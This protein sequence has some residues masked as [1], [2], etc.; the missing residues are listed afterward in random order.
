LTGGGSGGHITPLLSLARELKAQSPGC[1]I[2]YIGHKGDSFD[3]F[4]DSG[5]D[6]DFMA[7]VKAGKLRRYHGRGMAASVFNPKTLALNIRDFFRLP[8]SVLAAWHLLRKFKPDVVFSKGGFVAVPVGVAAKLL[9]IPIITHDSDAMPGLA[10]RIVGR[11]AKIHATGM[12]PENYSYPKHSIEYVGIPI[13]ERIKKVTPKIQAESKQRLKLPPDSSVLLVSGGGN[14][15]KRLNDLTLSIAPELLQTN[16]SLHIIHITGRLHESDVK[17]AYQSFPKPVRGRVTT[18]GYSRDFYSYSAAADLVISRGG[19][20][21]LAELSAAAKACIVI[22]APFLTGGH[23]LKN[24]E[25]LTRR[26]AAVVLDETVQP[27]ELLA[28]VSSLLSDDSR[29]FE[30][31][32]NLHAMAKPD[33]SVRLAALILKTAAKQ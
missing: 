15:S 18:L 17:A 28:P 22:P 4:K 21:T 19:A 3:T 12:P 7:F 31:A 16:L 8:G 20:T 29:R 24:A 32:R 11:W 13:D 14:G 5:H 27:D 26:D 1:Q 6:F 2:L 33:A 10:N 25:E 30:L 9:G 23:Q